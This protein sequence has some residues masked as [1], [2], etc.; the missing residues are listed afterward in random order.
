VSP[1]DVLL[2][3]REAGVVATCIGGSGLRLRVPASGMP[4][5][6]QDDVRRHKLAIRALIG[7]ESCPP[8]QP[9]PCF[10]GLTRRHGAPGF[11][12]ALM[13]VTGC[14][15]QDRNPNWEELCVFDAF[16]RRSGR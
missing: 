4:T 14:D 15:F 6:L 13:H 9:R 8:G 12:E 1:G 11:I 3:L 16:L 7:S 5:G 2:A 10:V